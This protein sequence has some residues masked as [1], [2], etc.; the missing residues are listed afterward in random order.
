MVERPPFESRENMD[1]MLDGSRIGQVARGIMQRE[2]YRS[3]DTRGSVLQ[4]VLR[5][6]E[7]SLH[8]KAFDEHGFPKDLAA[9]DE[10]E[11]IRALMAYGA[12][13]AYGVRNHTH[14]F[15]EAVERSQIKRA[16]MHA[17]V[18]KTRGGSGGA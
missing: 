15:E 2:W 17:W 7:D 9:V 12:G 13:D 1:L 16:Q 6:R 18:G 3:L 8:K 14:F 11:A 5:S 10:L 4:E